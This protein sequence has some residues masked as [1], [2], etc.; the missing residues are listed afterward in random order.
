MCS[1]GLG[2][3]FGTFWVVE[4]RGFAAGEVMMFILD[5]FCGLGGERVPALDSF[6][7]AD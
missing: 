6:S 3:A 4:V 7:P 2:W 1:V 5:P